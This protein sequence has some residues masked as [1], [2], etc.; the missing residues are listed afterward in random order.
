MTSHWD[1]LPVKLSEST[2]EAISALGFEECMP[3]QQSVIP[4]LLNSKDVAAEAVT[5][6][7][8]TL[9]F[10]VPM[11]EILLKRNRPWQTYEIGALILSPTCELAVQ[12]YE[13]V[14]HF[15]KFINMKSKEDSN[16]STLVFTG[17]GRSSGPTTKLQDFG[18]FKEKGSTVLVAT[19][20]RLTDL[21]LAGPVVDFGLGN[22]VNPIIRGLRSMEVLILDEADRLLE[23]GFDSQIN[24]ILSFLPKQRRTGLFSATQT[25]RVEDLV[26][27][28]LRNPVRVTVS[29]QTAKES[30]CLGDKPL[31][32]RTPSALQNYYAI[33]EPDEKI[34]L[35]VRFILAHRKAKILIFVATCA[36]V[37]YF[38]C[39]LKGL[40]PLKQSKRIEKLHGKLNKKRFNVFTKFKE[41]STGILLCTDVMA[42]GIDVP[43]IDWVIQCDPPTSANA[44]VHR[45]GR[46]ARCGIQGSALLFITSQEDAYINFLSINQQVNLKQMEQSITKR[47]RNLCKND[48]LLHEKAIRAFVS[49]V[50]FYRKHECNLL[51]N[52]KKL[53]FGRLANGFGLLQLPAMPELRTGNTSGFNPSN[54]DISK[55]T[56]RDKSV[57]KQRE[58]MQSTETPKQSKPKWVIK[59]DKNKA[60]IAKKKKARKLKSLKKQN[61]LTNDKLIKIDETIVCK[62]ENNSKAIDELLDDYRLLKRPIK[63]R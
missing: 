31:Q 59:K 62:E 46:T 26:R 40:L 8:K 61:L 43:H 19:P 18:A 16:F 7:G 21:I 51:L 45:C 47:I 35:I 23:M 32:Q 17:G 50:Q 6:S 53:D 30:D 20:G 41:T 5:G 3:V 24:T 36:C 13:I 49:Y 2:L 39:L 58:L 12:I 48:K 63:A 44:F 9:A 42:R 1:C 27:A 55:L 25:T 37:D 28:G 34:S 56:Y 33:V 38:Y 10:V 54:V 29:Q 4:L 15:I 14:L 60:W 11:L 52:Y 22:M 57:A